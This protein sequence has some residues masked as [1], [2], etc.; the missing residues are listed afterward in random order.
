M[1]KEDQIDRKVNAAIDQM[2]TKFENK[3][4]EQDNRI[5]VQRK[6]ITSLKQANAYY[7]NAQ[8]QWSR[9]V[10]ELE[11]FKVAMNE[12]FGLLRPSDS[13]TPTNVDEKDDV[14]LVDDKLKVEDTPLPFRDSGRPQSG[15][16]RRRIDCV[17]WMSQ[18]PAEENFY[19]TPV[20][21]L[22]FRDQAALQAPIPSQALFPK[23]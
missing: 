23:E 21:Q 1:A 17:N 14:R 4:K 18:E 5:N 11:Q 2:C 19:S 3:F 12:V 10:N 8:S 7:V 15:F 9:V 22:I 16:R 20:L 13:A 6:E